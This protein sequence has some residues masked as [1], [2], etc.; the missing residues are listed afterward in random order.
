MCAS[1][2]LTHM[3]N[4]KS[5]SQPLVVWLDDVEYW[6]RVA[7]FAQQE[8]GDRCQI[9]YFATDDEAARFVA[10]N[11][12]Q[13]AVVVQDINRLITSPFI[14]N[15]GKSRRHQRSSF[16]VKLQ[17]GDF[18]L[19]IID[20]FVPEATT[21]F[22]SSTIDMETAAILYK[23][24]YVDPRV[25]VQPKPSLLKDLYL[26]I[27]CGLERWENQ[28][29]MTEISNESRVLIPVADEI[30]AICGSDPTYF[31][32]ISSRQFEE[33]L[34]SVFR[35]QG[36]RVELTAA[37]R[38]GGYDLKV[39]QSS[40][41]KNEIMLVEA[42]KYSPSNTVPVSVVRALYGTKTLNNADR[43]ILVTTSRVSSYAKKEFERVLPAELEI[44]E[45]AT[46]EEWCSNYL[47][48]VLK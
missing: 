41:I 10:T 45:R 35:N 34:A 8:F 25:V 43:A 3:L 30:A 36:F 4:N 23:W 28:T 26:A 48:N 11:A 44:V 21:I 2:I 7:E 1:V 47:K 12:P 42:K 40:A 15:L 14:Q 13:V 38:D 9:N 22:H 33:V 46:L 6:G 20:C 24:S 16:P 31:E 5:A 39:I 27:D 29:G 18:Y 17:G 37:T 32:R 19:Y